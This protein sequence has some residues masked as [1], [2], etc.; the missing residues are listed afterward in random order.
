VSAPLPPDEA[1]FHLH[2]AGGRFRSGAAAGRWRFVS[3]S[4]PHAVFSV[5][6]A[7]GTEYGLRFECSNYPKTPPT[8]RLWDVNLGAPLAV[9]KW[10][11]GQ[12]R[13]P[14]AFNP[15]WKNGACLYLPC[16]RQSIEG[17]ANWYQQHPSLVWDPAIG[18]AHYLRVVHDLLNSGDYGGRRAA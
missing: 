18:I 1:V 12:H 4:W 5:R 17:H 16:D 6:A 8:G 15:D 3:V 2:L 7:D 14:L 10:P 13:I 11:T 9:N